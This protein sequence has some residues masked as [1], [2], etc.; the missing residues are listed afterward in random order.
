MRKRVLGVKPVIK[1]LACGL[2]GDGGRYLFL[3]QVD[4]HGIERLTLPCVLVYSGRSPVAELRGEFPG[5]TGIDGEIHEIIYEGRYNAGT[6][7]RKNWV[8]CLVFKVT[9]KKRRAAPSSE[10][11]GFRWLSLEDAKKQK[12][13][14][15]S[16]WLKK[17][18]SFPKAGT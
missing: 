15:K 6:R 11:S 16:E 5:Q 12:L 14:R 9:A 8:P 18:R 4:R 1:A 2:L 10:F 3:K 17:V 7:R 13:G